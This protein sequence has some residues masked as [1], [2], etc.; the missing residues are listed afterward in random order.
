MRKSV[1][2]VT[3]FAALSLT[4]LFAADQPR[5]QLL[6]LHSCELYA[7]GCTVSSEEPLDGRYMLRAWNF[8]GGSFAGVDLA[9]LRLAVLQSSA[10]NLAEPKTD[11]GQAV[12]YFPDS[13]TSSQREALLAWLKAAQPELSRVKLQT[14]A[15]ALEFASDTQGCTFSA[16][17]AVSVKTASLESC[18][19]GNCGEA[20]WYTPRTATTVFTVAVDRASRVS[21]PSLKVKWTDA[22]K[23]SIFLAKFGDAREAKNVYVTSAD[24]CGPTGKLF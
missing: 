5:G 18:D 15:V 1:L 13:A 8:S 24:L 2:I 16:G 9:G 23:R 21:E 11:P 4:T 19:R 12:V 6:E 17:D 3:G 14:R 10:A 22:G 7:G 20:L